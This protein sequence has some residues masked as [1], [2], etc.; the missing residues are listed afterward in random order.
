[1]APLHNCVFKDL[2]FAQHFVVL[3]SII[4]IVVLVIWTILTITLSVVF[5]IFV[6]VISRTLY[7]FIHNHWRLIIKNM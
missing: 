3:P 7:L 1:M 4:S 2:Q 5:I 6:G